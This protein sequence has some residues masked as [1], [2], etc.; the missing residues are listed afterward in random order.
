M[1]ERK[2]QKSSE[3]PLDYVQS[4]PKEE[5]NIED[6]GEMSEEKSEMSVLSKI[7]QDFGMDKDE[8][9][10]K[11]SD[12]DFMCPDPLE[13]LLSKIEAGLKVGI[14]YLVELY[15]QSFPIY[16][17]EKPSYITIEDGDD[18]EGLSDKL[19]VGSYLV[20]AYERNKHTPNVVLTGSEDLIEENE[21]CLLRGTK[22]SKNYVSEIRSEMP[23]SEGVE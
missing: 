1:K 8:I 22:S 16:D 19:D 10:P 23:N 3:T 12:H 20:T 4:E 11:G 13:K 15:D 18:L 5:T 9:R 21:E 7:A 2:N 6:I 17:R 14:T